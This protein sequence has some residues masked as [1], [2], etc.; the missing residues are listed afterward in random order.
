MIYLLGFG[1]VAQLVECPSKVPVWCNSSDVGW[2]HA[3]AKGRM[4]NCRKIIV[5]IILAATSMTKMG[6][7]ASI[8]R[9]NIS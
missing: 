8:R 1:P 9:K 4:K 7:I 5:N 3:V 2:N 6:K